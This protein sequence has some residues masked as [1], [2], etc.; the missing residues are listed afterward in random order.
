LRYFG[1]V[2]ATPAEARSLTRQPVPFGRQ[3]SL[4]ENVSLY[5]SGVGQAPSRLAAESLLKGGACALL[6][7]GSAG[8]L[9]SGLRPGSIILPKNV[10]AADQTNYPVDPKWHECL[11]R[12]LTGHLDIHSEP[13]AESIQILAYPEMKEALFRQTGAIAVDMESASVASVAHGAGV[14]F[15]AIRAIADSVDQVIPRTIQSA[16]DGFGRL[17]SLR[18]IRGLAKHP[19]DVF[20]LVRLGFGFRAAHGSLAAVRRLTDG[21]FCAP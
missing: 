20:P 6:S 15:L 3:V 21:A 16:F 4:R 18:A 11:W 8:G 19:G 17:N 5:L 1:I 13:L 2:V 9:V 12:R 7:W 14:L 10:I